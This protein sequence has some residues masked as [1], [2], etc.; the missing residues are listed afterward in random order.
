MEFANYFFIRALEQ[1][2]EVLKTRDATTWDVIFPPSVPVSERRR[3]RDLLI[4]TDIQFRLTYSVGI[5][6]ENTN[7]VST[8]LEGCHAI[9]Q[10]PMLLDTQQ[11]GRAWSMDRGTVSI[12]IV[13]YNEFLMMTI[14]NIVRTIISSFI[15]DGWFL[16]A[17]FDIVRRV[18]SQDLRVETGSMPENVTKYIRQQTWE[19]AMSTYL[20]HI[21]GPFDWPVKPIFVADSTVECDSILDPTTGEEYDLGETYR[22][23]VDPEP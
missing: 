6:N 2:W 7:V 22:G 1:G 9:E 5:T 4:R 13:T 3:A 23:G 18:G 21:E 10:T 11:D 16:T 15:T 14:A 20:P 8:G 19:C 17:G 12:Y